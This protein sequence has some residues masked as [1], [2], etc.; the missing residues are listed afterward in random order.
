M[1]V[2]Y[3]QYL[4]KHKA[5]VVK[6][7][8]WLEKYL[9]EYDGI[10]GSNTRWNV[11]YAHD[12]SKT[13]TDEYEAYDAYFYGGNRSYQVV[14]NYNR[15]WLLHLHR[16]PH[17]WQYWVLINDDPKEGKT[18]LDMPQDYIVE[19]I[20]D[21]WSFSWSK[22]NLYEIFN[23]Y[24]E[25]R[26]YIK[27]SEAT[28]RTVED[29]LKAIRLKLDEL[30]EGDSS[31]L[32]HHGVKGQKWG[33][34]NGPPYPIDKTAKRDTIVE[35]AIESGQVSRQ[36]NPEKQ[37]RHTKSGHLPGR[38]YL[39]GDLDYAQELVDELSG[40]GTPVLSNSGKW[41]RM[42]RVE[43]SEEI[44]V[45]VDPETGKETRTSKAMIRYSKTG[46]HIHPRKG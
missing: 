25:R 28:R 19:M 24:D 27:L 7:F 36:I 45:L 43:S 15:A 23:W 6:A 8:E 18:C 2:L 32:M 39:D 38:S 13:E 29:I 9:P 16:N 20:C 12:A 26:Q 46:S 31:E 11:T 34:K 42:E 35:E 33:V 14:Q 10:D 1:S 5:N 21:W 44:G 30:G 22:G 41:L 3:D 37:M 40:T 4:Q 17:H